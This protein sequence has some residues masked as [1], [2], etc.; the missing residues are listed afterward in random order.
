MN[1]RLQGDVEGGCLIDGSGRTRRL[2]SPLLTEIPGLAHA[3]TARGAVPGEAIA[4][5]AGRPLPIA[6]LRQVHGAEV[7]ALEDHAPIA[8]PGERPAG[9]ALITRRRGVGLEVRIADC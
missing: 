9:D 2:T 6:S 3:F 1:Q 8:A 7:H 4:E 5:A